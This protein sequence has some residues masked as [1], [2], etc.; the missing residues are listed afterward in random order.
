MVRFRLPILL[1]IPVGIH[2]K[3]YMIDDSR[4]ALWTSLNDENVESTLF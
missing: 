3:S 2:R 4:D 1:P